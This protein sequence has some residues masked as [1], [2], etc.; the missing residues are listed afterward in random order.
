MAS[1]IDQGSKIDVCKVDVTKRA[2]CGDLLGNTL[3]C[4]L[5]PGY[6]GVMNYTVSQGDVLNVNFNTNLSSTVIMGGSL[7]GGF[8]QDAP[9]ELVGHLG[10]AASQPIALN[11]IT[12]FTFSP[13][14][15]VCPSFQNNTDGTLSVYMF[16]SATGSVNVTGGDYLANACRFTINLKIERAADAPIRADQFYYAN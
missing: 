2:S 9:C 13:S 7:N 3:P 4:P 12:G 11:T 14:R 1:L 10:T 8:A 5:T 16:D 6:R 15:A